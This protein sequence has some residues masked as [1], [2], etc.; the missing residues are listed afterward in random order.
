LPSRLIDL[1]IE[2]DI[3]PRLM[4][5]GAAAARYVALSYCW[6]EDKTLATTVENIFA[7]MADLKFASLPKAYQNLMVIARSLKIRYVWIDALCIVQNDAQDWA[8]GTAEM[9]S[10]YENA[11]VTVSADCSPG[12]HYG[13]FFGADLC[14]SAFRLFLHG[15]SGKCQAVAADKP[16][17]T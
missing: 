9:C 4:A 16:H 3:Q 5:V 7:H 15:R 12:V 14:N 17:P 8:R 13:I 11:C 2:E 1:G 10:I 6:G